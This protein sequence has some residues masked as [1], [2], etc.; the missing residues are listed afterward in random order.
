MQ[1]NVRGP[2]ADQWLPGPGAEGNGRVDTQRGKGKLLRAMGMV[3]SPPDCGDG[4][5][6]I[7]MSKHIKL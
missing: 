7:A 4:F 5:R 2:K 6:C 1:T 3:C